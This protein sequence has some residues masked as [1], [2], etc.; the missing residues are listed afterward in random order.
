MD[1]HTDV[2]A[3]AKCQRFYVLGKEIEAK[4]ARHTLGSFFFFYINDAASNCHNRKDSQIQF[5]TWMLSMWMMVSA[6]V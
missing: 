2:G 5:N 6:A 4:Y 3:A 1:V